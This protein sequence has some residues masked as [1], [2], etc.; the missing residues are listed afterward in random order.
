MSKF[1]SNG[2]FLFF[3]DEGNGAPVILLHGL[4]ASHSMFKHEIKYLK[5]NFR[6]I[7]IDFRG[8]GESDKPSHYSLEDHIQDVIA[9]MDHLSLE[10]VNLLGASMGSYIAQGVAI[11]VPERIDKLILVVPKS[12]GK[13]SSSMRLLAQYADKIKGL[14]P[15]ETAMHLAK[16]IFHNHQA[17]DQFTKELEGTIVLTPK[18]YDVANKAL[19][20]FDFRPNLH[21]ITA[22]TIIISG[23]YDGL[24]P[25]ELGREMA[26][27]ISKARFIEFENSGHAPNV[28][29]HNLFKE[30]ILDFLLGGLK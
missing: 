22:R 27:Y 12:N 26:S 1:I 13:T 14:S 10:K 24:N 29:E 20:G 30:S 16:Y 18:E 15:E 23:R 17:M 3:K 9:L 21:K 4:G 11:E 8:H 28:E 5:K 2:T 6:V 25:P 19:E 7:A